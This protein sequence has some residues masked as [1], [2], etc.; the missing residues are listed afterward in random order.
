[1]RIVFILLEAL[2]FFSCHHRQS[3][4]LLKIKPIDELRPV[5]P[6]S[7]FADS[8]AFIQLD[9]RLLLSS[10]GNSC[11]TDSFFVVSVAEGILKYSYTGEFLMKIGE[12]GQGPMEYNRNK[13]M[14]I[15]TRNKRIRVYSIP[16]KVMIDYSYDGVFLNRVHYD[17]PDD[18]YGYPTM[19]RVL[20]K[21]SYFFLTINVR[22]IRSLLLGDK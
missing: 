10:Y 13:L 16:E 18:T 11:F 19:M 7:D 12:I 6:I 3:T 20:A 1:M 17:L 8:I 2:L 22:F 4:E 21:K 9:N 14:A 15:D 5:I